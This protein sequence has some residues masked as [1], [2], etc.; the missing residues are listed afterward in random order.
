[1]RAGRAVLLTSGAWAGEFLAQQLGEPGWAQAVRPRRGHL[2]E[3]RRPDGMPVLHR[4]V[5]E[6]GYTAH[7]SAAGK[8]A[9]ASA[10]AGGAA[11]ADITFTATTS[12]A[13]TL[14]VG[15]SREFGG[16]GG[17]ADARVV[18]AIMRRAAAFLPALEAVP[19]RDISIRV[20]LRPFSPVR[21]VSPQR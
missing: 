5:M 16:W 21:T 13:G 12:A 6:V 7:Y 8:Q 15:S 4:G 17:E 19:L 3:M 9:A 10:A 20:G 1:V 18:E 2:L 11:P 14:L